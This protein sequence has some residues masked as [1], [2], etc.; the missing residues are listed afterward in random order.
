MKRWSLFVLMMIVALLMG[1]T[2]SEVKLGIT[3][4]ESTQKLTPGQVIAITL[5]SNPSTGYGWQ[6]TG[7]MPAILQ[8][9]EIGRAHV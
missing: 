3:A 6:V 4:S 1:C 9:V 5:D 7:E 8:Q 2:A